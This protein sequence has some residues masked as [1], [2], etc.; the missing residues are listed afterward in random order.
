MLDTSSLEK[1]RHIANSTSTN[2]TCC[3]IT[4]HQLFKLKNNLTDYEI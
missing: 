3:F 4:P 2:H 1:S